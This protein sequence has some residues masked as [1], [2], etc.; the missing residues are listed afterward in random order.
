MAAVINSLVATCKDNQIDFEAWLT[1]ILPKLGKTG[2]A[3][4]DTLLPHL[5]KTEQ[6]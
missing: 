1:D 2:M 4:I 6:N 5:W 3:D